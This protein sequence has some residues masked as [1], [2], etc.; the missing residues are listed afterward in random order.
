MC[1]R[2]TRNDYGV[3]NFRWSCDVVVDD[4][5]GR[6][7]IIDIMKKRRP[8][9]H[10]YSRGSGTKKEGCEVDGRWKVVEVQMRDIPP[11][12]SCTNDVFSHVSAAMPVV[13]MPVWGDNSFPFPSLSTFSIHFCPPADKSQMVVYDLLFVDK[14]QVSQGSGSIAAEFLLASPSAAHQLIKLR[15]TLQWNNLSIFFITCTRVLLFTLNGNTTIISNIT[16]TEVENDKEVPMYR[17]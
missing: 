15:V 5:G 3:A 1:E 9:W 13:G 16:T 6:D 8:T 10:R 17:K 2:G 4:V 12:P 7:I 11:L 14:H